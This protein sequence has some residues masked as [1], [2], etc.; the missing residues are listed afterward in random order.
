MDESENTGDKHLFLVWN[1]EMV[2]SWAS[3][4]NVNYVFVIVTMKVVS[5]LHLL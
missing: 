3:I 5:Y 4:N 1:V 2:N